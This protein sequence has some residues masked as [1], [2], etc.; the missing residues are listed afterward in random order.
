[1][2][3]YQLIFGGQGSTLWGQI[4]D[5]NT[6]LLME[7]STQSGPPT[8]TVWA[9]DATYGNGLA[10]V[11]AVAGQAVG[12]VV[13]PTFDNFSVVPEPSTWA[14]AALGLLGLAVRNVRRCRRA[15]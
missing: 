3:D 15:L 4:K 11:I 2:G 7:F 9:V 6:G 10:G 12:T 8:N 5:L 1:L 13:N 14:L